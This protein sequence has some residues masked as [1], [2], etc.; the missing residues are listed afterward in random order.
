MSKIA[1]LSDHLVPL[2][3]NEL[4]GYASFTE[5]LRA[6]LPDDVYRAI[7]HEREY[8]N[9]IEAFQKRIILKILK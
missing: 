3:L 4:F 8:V 1:K 7:L 9:S 5:G 2:C 6:H